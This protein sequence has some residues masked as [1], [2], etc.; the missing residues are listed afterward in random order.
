MPVP[1]QDSFSQYDASTAYG[2]GSFQIYLEFTFAARL[3]TALAAYAV[4]VRWHRLVWIVEAAQEPWTA[5]RRAERSDVVF[6]KK[7]S[8]DFYA[9]AASSTRHTIGGEGT[10]RVRIA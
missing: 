1:T 5:F 6:R 10:S 8:G 7:H 2:S 4:T 3:P 9:L